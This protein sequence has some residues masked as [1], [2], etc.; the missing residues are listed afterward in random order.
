M[1]EEHGSLSRSSSPLYISAREDVC[2]SS[3]SPSFCFGFNCSIPD[4][5]GPAPSA[6]D[7]SFPSRL[8]FV[9]D[10]PL[11]A[12]LCLPWCP[13][14][15]PASPRKHSARTNSF[16]PHHHGNY[17]LIS[18]TPPPPYLML[19][20]R[21]ICQLTIYLDIQAHTKYVPPRVPGG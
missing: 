19:N 1:C 21:T 4:S 5:P 18:R 17:F 8:V 12:P 3:S 11:P 13:L 2:A 6:C 14:L 15:L 10:S 7:V 20:V 16:R 9:L